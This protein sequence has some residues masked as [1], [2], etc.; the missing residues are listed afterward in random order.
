MKVTATTGRTIRAS[1]VF[2]AVMLTG[3]GGIENPPGGASAGS[4]GMGGSTSSGSG[5]GSGEPVMCMLEG[6][7]PSAMAL[8]DSAVVAAPEVLA[9]CMARRGCHT[10]LCGPANVT[11]PSGCVLGG[12]PAE[13]ADA[14]WCCAARCAVDADCTADGAMCADGFCN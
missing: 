10:E 12:V 13:S 14:V 5:G 2:G 9:F 1:L 7:S 4:G 3:C 11:P 8:C 6:N